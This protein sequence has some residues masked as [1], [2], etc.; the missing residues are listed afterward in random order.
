MK[1]GI[2]N[3]TSG[4]TVFP[5]F[6]ASC[7]EVFPKFVSKK[8]A[9]QYEMENGTLEYVK[10]RTA[11]YMEKKQIQIKCEV[12]KAQEGE[13][14][15]WAP[16]YLFGPDADDWPKSYLCRACHRKW[17]DMVTPN[18]TRQPKMKDNQT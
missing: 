1:I 13:L 5:Y 9:H 6:C 4:A 7:G 15:H 18:M 17:H 3:I 11:K 8:V 12:C 10:T 14:H 2:T 16:Q